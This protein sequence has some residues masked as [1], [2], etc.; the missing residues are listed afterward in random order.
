MMPLRWL[1][2]TGAVLAMAVLPRA[3]VSQVDLATLGPQVGNRA[4]DFSLPDQN[5]RIQ[6]LESVAGPSG[7]MLV[8]FRSADW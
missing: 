7:T 1:A 3:Q 8:F 6:N 4:I 5:G 2:T